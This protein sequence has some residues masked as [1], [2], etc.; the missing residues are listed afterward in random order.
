MATK[1]AQGDL[2]QIVRHDQWTLGCATQT[3]FPEMREHPVKELEIYSHP[4]VGKLFNC[5]EGKI[6]LIVYVIKNRLDQHM[7]YRVLIEGKE[8]LCKSKVATKYFKLVESHNN[9]SRGSGSFQD[10]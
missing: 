8:M 2:I 3:E 4:D 9:E 7:G 10:E 6:G 5:I 1:F